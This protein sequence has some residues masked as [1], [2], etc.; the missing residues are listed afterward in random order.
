MTPREWWRIANAVSNGLF[1]APDARNNLW[2]DAARGISSRVVTAL[3]D[4]TA[5]GRESEWEAVDGHVLTW[6]WKTEDAKQY[7]VA[8][9]GSTRPYYVTD[10]HG[11]HVLVDR[12]ERAGVILCSGTLAQCMAHA[13]RLARAAKGE[14][15]P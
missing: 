15:K 1:A 13:E 8:H 4:I 9:A 3:Y 7:V 2:L 6:T 10:L 14:A 11:T 12:E 5:N